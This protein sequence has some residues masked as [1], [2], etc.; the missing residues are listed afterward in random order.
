MSKRI[1]SVIAVALLL[2]CAAA[3]QDAKSVLDSAS[4][5]MGAASLNSISYSGTGSFFA[6]GQSAH[7]NEAWPRFDAKSYSYMVNYNTPASREELVR[8]QAL[9]PPRG[10]GNQPV[11]GELRQ[12]Q[13]LS[14]TFAWN[15][16]GNNP[17]PTPAA[18]TDRNLLIWATPH[19][20][21]KAALQNNAT[22]KSQTVGGKKL[23]VVSFTT[24]DKRKMTGYIND[25][26]LV[27]RVETW[28]DNPVLGD[29]LV[30]A[31]YSDYKDFGG[32][33]FP[34]KIVQEQ[35]GYPVLDLTITEVQ[36]N[37]AVDIAVPEPVRQATAPSPVRVESQK[38][39]E[40]VHF[41]GGGSH[42]SVAIE[43]KDYITVIEGPQSEERSLAVLGEVKRLYPNKPIRYLVNSHHHFDHSGGIRTF[44]A[45][46]ITIVTHQANKPFY[47]RVLKAP[48]TI[49]PDKLAMAK[50]TPRVETVAD[51]K[52]ITDGSRTLELYRFQGNMH[53]EVMIMAY[54]PAE[55]ILIEADMFTPLPPGAAPAIPP[56]PFTVNLYDNLARLKLDIAQIAPLHGRVVPM[57]DFLKAVGKSSL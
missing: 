37:A 31:R 23:N 8:T 28:I 51:K 12:V 32:V 55:K 16:A 26:N 9:N 39:A 48:H 17:V 35:G 2:S 57:D 34:G 5:A 38:I 45:E 44:A 29:M 14:G 42:N 43:F 22:V 36:P 7:P 56:S 11:R 33:K 53:N 30:Q 19:G 15:V 4:Q 50:V 54:L 41:V 20:F 46:G 13:V 3:A 25:Q 18:A 24:A 40:G 1:A 21:L 6:L 47:D 27:E 49:N 52:V 10:G